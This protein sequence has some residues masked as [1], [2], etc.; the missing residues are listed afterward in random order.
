MNFLE[1]LD[2]L[3]QRHNLNIH[4]LSKASGIPYSTIMGWYK[5]ENGYDNIKLSQLKKLRSF[6]HVSLEYLAYDEITDFTCGTS[7]G[8]AP[9]DKDLVEKYH[10]LDAGH[11]GIVNAVLNINEENRTNTDTPDILKNA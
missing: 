3:M 4:T 8:L 7:D 10:G 6:F 11:K 1:K 5:K 9:E 2:F